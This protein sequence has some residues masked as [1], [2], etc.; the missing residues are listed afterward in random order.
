MSQHMS[1]HTPPGEFV[2]QVKSALAALYDLPSLQ[3]HPLLLQARPPA[4]APA[5]PEGAGQWLRRELVE[6]IE[7]LSPGPGAAFRAPAA[8]PHQLLHLHYVEGLPIQETGRELG[9]SERQTYRDLRQAEQSLAIVLWERW[10]PPEA[11]AAELTTADREMA[12][13]EMQLAP[14]DFAALVQQALEAVAR[15]AADGGVALQPDLPPGLAR[16]FGVASPTI[17][18]RAR[19]RLVSRSDVCAL[20]GRGDQ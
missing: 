19:A 17:V 11:G 3:R 10:R 7:S 15:L 6:G 1:Q 2:Q 5:G 20:V 14:A 9:L 12:R 4:G 18:A 13:W 8:R 16:V